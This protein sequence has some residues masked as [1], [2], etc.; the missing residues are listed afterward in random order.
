VR[1]D[2]SE[3][4]PLGPPN[5][6]WELINRIFVQLE[7]EGRTP[8]PNYTWSL[9]HAGNI[10]RTLGFERFAAIEF[11][12]AGGNGLVALEGAA[13]AVQQHLGVG[14]DVV[15]FDHGVGLPPPED[16]R[17]AP[18]LMEAGQFAMDEAKLRARLHHAQLHIGLVR[19]TLA[20]FIA[21]KPAPIGFISFDLDYYSSTI[22]AFKLFDA[23][24]EQFFPRV[25]CYFDD[26]LGY[27][28]GESNGERLAIA[29]FNRTH[30]NR[31][32]DFLPG[33]RY[34]LPASEFHARWVESMYAAHILDHPR[35]SEDEGVAIVT[36]LDLA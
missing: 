5:N 2:E 30:P 16:Y 6:H 25:L 24:A 20:S 12:V 31:I 36:R 1:G 14:V 32:I 3:P 9:L 28:W 22:D 23:P 26:V 33:L 13:D 7:R 27:P 17:D 18:Y 19:D 35:A 4:E 15:G 34:S 8:R 21:S 11:G 29:D 10:A